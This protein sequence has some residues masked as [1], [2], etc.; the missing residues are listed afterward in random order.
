MCVFAT[1]YFAIDAHFIDHPTDQTA[2]FGEFVNFECRVSSCSHT[3][4]FLV[5]GKGLGHLNIPATDFEVYFRESE[6]LCEQDQYVKTLSIIVNNKTLEIVKY[7]SCNLTVFANG[8]VHDI[9][10]N[11]AYIVNITNPYQLLPTCPHCPAATECA[12][13][14]NSIHNTARKEQ[15]SLLLLVTQ[16]LITI[17]Y[18]LSFIRLF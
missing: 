9:P 16:N 6:A 8:A 3:L 4:K 1:G 18:I 14:N 11:R 2:A 17:A 10:S 12:N 5:N 15:Q 13:R 7:I